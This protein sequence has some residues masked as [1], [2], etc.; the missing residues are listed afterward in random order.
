MNAK[1]LGRLTPVHAIGRAHARTAGPWPR[2]ESARAHDGPVGA[3]QTSWPHHRCA[4]RI[5]MAN[6]QLEP[7]RTLYAPARDLS[8]V[9]F[10]IRRLAVSARVADA[11]DG[12]S[13]STTGPWTRG[14]A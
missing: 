3:G 1:P 9:N 11:F 7:R 5:G 8:I 14:P 13:G 6:R 2:Q 10:T 4:R 12:P